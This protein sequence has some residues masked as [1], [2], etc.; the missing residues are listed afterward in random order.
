M[1][2]TSSH[3]ILD[4]EVTLNVI[5]QNFLMTDM[6]TDVTKCQLTSEGSES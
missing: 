1:P 3:G 2:R 4:L 6:E 5:S